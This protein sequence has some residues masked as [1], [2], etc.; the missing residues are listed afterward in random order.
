M[1]HAGLRSLMQ[2]NSLINAFDYAG[3]R[4]KQLGYP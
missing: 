1:T 4:P 3:L 2:R